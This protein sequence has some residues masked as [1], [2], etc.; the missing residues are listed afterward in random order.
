MQ[1]T[2]LQPHNIKLSTL[3]SNEEVFARNDGDNPR[4]LHGDIID[5]E[6]HAI[7][8][9]SEHGFVPLAIVVSDVKIIKHNL[10]WG[11]C[12]WDHHFYF[13]ILQVKLQ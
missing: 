5:C 3:T 6:L 4:G 7:L 8:R 10:A 13:A 2:V 12:R 1:D 9:H 11:L